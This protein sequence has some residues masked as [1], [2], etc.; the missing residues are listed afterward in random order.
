VA[1]GDDGGSVENR[2]RF[3]PDAFRTKVSASK[4]VRLGQEPVYV[5][6]RGYAVTGRPHACG[7]HCHRRAA[8]FPWSLACHLTAC[9]FHHT[10]K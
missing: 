1:D 10:M 8:R 5:W 4:A 2:P 9:T 7:G 6:V 3:G